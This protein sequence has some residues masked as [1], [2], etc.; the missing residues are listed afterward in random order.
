MLKFFKF[1]Q[2]GIVSLQI[3]MSFASFYLELKEFI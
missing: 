2:I 1:S 3:K